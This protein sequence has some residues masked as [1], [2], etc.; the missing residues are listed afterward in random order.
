MRLDLS[1]YYPP[2]SF[3]NSGGRSIFLFHFETGAI[4]PGTSKS[5]RIYGLRARLSA[6]ELN[7]LG[8]DPKL[9]SSWNRTSWCSKWD[10]NPHALAGTWFWVRRVYQFRHSSKSKRSIYRGNAI[11]SITYT[12]LHKTHF[13]SSR[14]LAPASVEGI[15]HLSCVFQGLGWISPA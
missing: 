11:A 15:S 6:C 10:S 2:E 4:L 3:L 8:R 7:P 13:Q 14:P 1:R 9:S 5:Q 12:N